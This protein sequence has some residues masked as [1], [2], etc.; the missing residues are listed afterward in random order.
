MKNRY[1]IL[2]DNLG[3]DTSTVGA[4]FFGD[5][6]DEA[7]QLFVDGKSEEEVLFFLPRIYLENYHFDYGVGKKTYFNEINAF[8]DSKRINKKSRVINRRFSLL[9]RRLSLDE[10]VIF[11]SKYFYDVD[12]GEKKEIKVYR[13][14]KEQG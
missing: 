10:F 13:L 5:L 14:K 9:R 6:I 12:M 8:L 4:M 3:Y 11:I 2:L 7:Y 1:K